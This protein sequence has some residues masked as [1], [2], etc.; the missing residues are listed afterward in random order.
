[1]P[2]AYWKFM[3]F[4]TLLMFNRFSEGF[5]TLRAK[6]ILPDNVGDFP[7]FMALYELF[8][9]CIAVIIGRISDGIDQRKIML[10]GVGLLI[11]AD[12]FAI[13]ASGSITVILSYIFAGMHIGSTQGLI[14][15]M[16]AKLA[17]KNLI[18]TAF[19]LFYG[20]EGI[21][22]FLANNIAGYS[23]GLAKFI[24][25]Q[26]SSVPFIFGIIFSIISSFYIFSWIKKEKI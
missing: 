3:I 18:G 17:P 13:S 22:L 21:T 2:K 15:S 12:V 24:S 14:G 16:I 25:V 10:F 8:A 26:S 11:I 20:I 6:E 4:I 9:I 5:I 23:S 1:M 19:A 7:L